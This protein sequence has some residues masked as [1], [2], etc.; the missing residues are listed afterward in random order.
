MTRDNGQGGDPT[1][2]L[3]INRVL[4]AEA[5]A[6]DAIADCRRQAEALLA[7]AEADARRI[8]E[9]AER[10]IRDAQ[11]IADR[12][13]ARALAALR[14]SAAAEPGV[15]APDAERLEATVARLARELTEPPP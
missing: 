3:A 14:E 1:V 11:A 7:R 5:E 4:G 15:G 9:R 2:D 8:A 13:I 6:R 10:R 12:G